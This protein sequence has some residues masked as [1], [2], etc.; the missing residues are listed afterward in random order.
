MAIFISYSR[1]DKLFVDKLC[2]N[3]VSEKVFLW[4]DRWELKPGDSLI[5]SIQLALQQAGAVLIVLSKNYIESAWCKKEM[6]T[7]LIRELEEKGNVIIPVVI[8]N[9]DTPPFLREKLYADFRTNWDEGYRSLGEALSKFT[10]L[11]QG[12]IDTPEFHVDY[13]SE[14]FTLNNKISGIRYQFIEHAENRP[15]SILSIL[16]IVFRDKWQKRYEEYTK[17][18][19]EETARR[20][21]TL[22]LIQFLDDEKIKVELKNATPIH[23]E[24]G[25]VDKKSGLSAMLK[26][27]IRWMGEDTGKTIVYWAGESIKGALVQFMSKV[28]PLSPEERIM[29]KK[30]MDKPF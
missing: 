30:I 24:I 21:L 17:A 6:N 14:Y 25:F 8:E 13:S 5:D 18:G 28:K 2:R 10:N 4:L 12:R 11:D 19:L 3:L 7:S 27:E 9:C 23:K 16:H 15:F 20:I 29:M 26:L 1:K 22:V